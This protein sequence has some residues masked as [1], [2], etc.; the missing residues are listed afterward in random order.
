MPSLQVPLFIDV[1]YQTKGVKTTSTQISHGLSLT[2]V[3]WG[4]KKGIIKESVS[5]FLHEVATKIIDR[6]EAFS[7]GAVSLLSREEASSLLV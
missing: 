3:S 1:V 2:L 7:P 4:L 5:R 6:T